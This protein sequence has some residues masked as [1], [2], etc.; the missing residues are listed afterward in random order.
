MVD[1]SAREIRCRQ[2]VASAR[3]LTAPHVLMAIADGGVTKG[4]VLAVARTAG[5]LA[6]KQTPRL[7]PLCH[8]IALHGVHVDLELADDGVVVTATTRTA[9]R[10]GVE[11]EALTAVAIAGLTVI[12]MIKAM[13][14]AARLTEVRVEHKT[15][16][17]TGDWH[18]KTAE[19]SVEE[20]GAT[21]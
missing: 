6:A 9:D 20:D 4:D 11:M 19:P 16:G 10:T 2:A 8:P 5:I 15:G 7:I 18:R 14:P 21:C 3:V 13:D 12:D 1:V 17:R